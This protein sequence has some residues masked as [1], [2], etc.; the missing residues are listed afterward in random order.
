M[1]TRVK[2][3]GIRTLK[4]AQ[5]AIEAGADY[6]GFN[7]VPS[8]RRFIEPR[9]AL[10]IIN[11]IKDKVKI[12][13]VFQNIEITMVNQLIKQLD[14]DFV[15]L[16]GKESQDYVELV[17]SRVIKTI[18]SFN[19]TKSYSA[20]YFLVDRI[21]QGEGDMVNVEEVRTI[22]NKYLVFLAGGLTPENVANSVKKIQPFAVDV[23]SGIETN[24]EQ[25]IEKIKT[26]IKNAKE[27]I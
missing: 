9:Q 13:G 8:S 7:F 15:Q 24:G 21:K 23:A 11:K 27:A 19:E 18:V 20:D 16:H 5:V 14:L 4:A 6:L 10:E 25:D 17:G 2:I 26:F 12:V 3:C 22:V 1:N